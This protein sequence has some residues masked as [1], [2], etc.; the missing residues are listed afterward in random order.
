MVKKK[1]TVLCSV[2]LLIAGCIVAICVIFN[3]TVKA[4]TTD[5][6]EDSYIYEETGLGSE[7][8]TNIE[9]HSPSEK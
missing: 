6:S 7:T 4:G 2:F 8:I 3:N 1:K 9:N 5:Y